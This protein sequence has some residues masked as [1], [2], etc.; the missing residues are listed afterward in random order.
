MPVDGA[1]RKVVVRP[2][3]NGYIYVLDR[4]ATGEVLSADPFFE[5][6]NTSKG[7]DLKTGRLIERSEEM[8]RPGRRYAV[9]VDAQSL[10]TFGVP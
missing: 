2:E 1:D 6:I 8:P 10:E 4:R 5:H 9:W 7:V 3:R